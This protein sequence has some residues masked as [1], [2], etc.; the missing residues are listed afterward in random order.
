M[1]AVNSKYLIV[2]L[3]TFIDS[4]LYHSSETLKGQSLLGDYS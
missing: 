2:A 4:K 3:V 1:D